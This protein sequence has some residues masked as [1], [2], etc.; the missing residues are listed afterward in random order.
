MKAHGAGSR[1]VTQRGLSGEG[2]RWVEV[3]S[4]RVFQAIPCA[5]GPTGR[6]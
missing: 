1:C 3:T 4:R 6:F 2:E 5:V